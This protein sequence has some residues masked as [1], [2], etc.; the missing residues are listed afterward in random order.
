[1]PLPAAH[2][3]GRVATQLRALRAARATRADVVQIADIELLPWAPL[4]RRAGR[5]VTYDCIEDYPAYMAIKSWLPRAVRPVA[6][7]TVAR[8]ERFVAPRVDAVFT[9]DAGTA[10]RLRGYGADVAVLHNFPRRDDF[11]PAPPDAPRPHDVVYHGSLPPYHLAALA[12]IAC[13]LGTRVPSARWTIVGAPDGDA[14]RA[15]FAARVAEGGMGDRV[16]L[17]PRLG[18]D[19]IRD[20]LRGARTGVVPLPDVP[21]FRTNVPM[22]V[23]EYLAAGVPAVTSDLPPIRRVLD[24]TDAAI[25]VPPGDAGA[26]ADALAHLLTDQAAAAAQARRGRALVDER[27]HWE[28]EE[29]VLLARYATLLG[30]AARVSHARQEARA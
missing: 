1:V 16:R 17:A 21:K 14:A 5:A 8:L 29:R 12:E 26:F 30:R 15:A 9:A 25:L 27:L 13:A 22:K 7:R 3:I 19:A 2:G 4:L 24:G 28:R 11:R 18:F 20:F 23:F 10:D 6:A